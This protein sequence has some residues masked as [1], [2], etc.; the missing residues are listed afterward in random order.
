MDNESKEKILQIANTA[1]IEKGI[2][3]S[4]PCKPE[5][6]TEGTFFGL[7]RGYYKVYMGGNVVGGNIIVYISRKTMT[8]TR[9]D[10]RSR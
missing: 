8:V 10:Q 1:L 7:L 9:I 4:F 5:V 6:E 3:W 2:K